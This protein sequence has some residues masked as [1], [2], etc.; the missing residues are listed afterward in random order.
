MSLDNS[1]Q[2]LN[3]VLVNSERV[4]NTPLPIAYAIAISQITWLYVF[5]LPFQL[6]LDLGWITIPATVA[7]SYIILGIFFIGHEIEN[8]FGNDV[9]DLPLDLFC[10]QIVEDMETIAARRKPR[11]S[12]WVNNPKNKVLY[13][14]S[15][16]SYGV[17]AQRPEQA[18]R[19]VLRNRPHADFEKMNANG[20]KGD[21][22]V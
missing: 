14:H 1:L 2:A 17:W 5:L 15:D 16:S 19:N 4:L 3:D 21:R 12:E 20:E 18:I 10:Q 8:P 9:N 6:L 7:A 11:M 22:N 13:P